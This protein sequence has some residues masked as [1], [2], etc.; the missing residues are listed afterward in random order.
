MNNMHLTIRIDK[1]LLESIDKIAKYR[2]LD[3]SAIVRQTIRIG[4]QDELTEL[5]IKLYS[6]GELTTSGGAKFCDMYIGDF[7]SLL[8]KRGVPND[9]PDEIIEKMHKNIGNL[10]PMKEKPILASPKQKIKY[11]LSKTKKKKKISK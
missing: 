6:E 7:M 10:I 5:A 1:D 9:I 3:R 8:A 2:Y 11:S 4:V